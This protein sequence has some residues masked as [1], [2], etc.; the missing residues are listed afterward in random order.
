MTAHFLWMSVNEYSDAPLQVT[1]R[2][3]IFPYY[4]QE[5][6]CNPLVTIWEMVCLVI[7]IDTDIL[8]RKEYYENVSIK[9]IRHH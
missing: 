1:E 5:S 9:C 2:Y 8:T 7:P 4:V 3:A 6:C